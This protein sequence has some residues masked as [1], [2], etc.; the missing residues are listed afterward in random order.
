MLL[1]GGMFQGVGN[2]GI[3]IN[4]FA[5]AATLAAVGGTLVGNIACATVVTGV[6]VAL[7]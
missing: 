1:G 5:G 3:E 6:T 7:V 2:G 4:A